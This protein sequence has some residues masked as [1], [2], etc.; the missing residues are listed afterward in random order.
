MVNWIKTQLELSNYNSDDEIT[1]AKYF[2]Y[3][4]FFFKWPRITAP[5]ADRTEQILD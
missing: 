1:K 2:D 3:R 5:V 4:I